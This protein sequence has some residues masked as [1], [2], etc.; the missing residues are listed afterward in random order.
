ME[1]GKP[2]GHQG[3]GT[4]L[5]LRRQ[6]RLLRGNYV[7]VDFEVCV[8]VLIDVRESSLLVDQGLG[9]LTFLST[10]ALLA[11]VTAAHQPLSWTA[12]KT[13]CFQKF[14]FAG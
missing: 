2:E 5:N 3:G 4:H 10:K 11:A 8:G 6:N 9:W 13:F 7:K 14:P 1:A 12:C